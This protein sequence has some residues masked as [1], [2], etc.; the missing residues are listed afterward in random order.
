MFV[1]CTPKG[2]WFGSFVATVKDLTLFV[3]DP[4]E[5][6]FTLLSGSIA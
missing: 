3:D 1:N 2:N 5:S 4:T 6:V